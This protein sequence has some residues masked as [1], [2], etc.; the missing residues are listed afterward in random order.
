[1]L[2]P[3]EQSPK[4]SDDSRVTYILD[5]DLV[6]F[7][8]F[9]VAVLAVFLIVG[10]YLFG[11]KLESALEKVR[12]TQEDMK[13]AQEKLSL[14]QKEL[15][16]ALSMTQTLKSDVE[17]VLADAQQYVTEISAQRTVAVEIV[18]SMRELTPQ[19]KAELKAV[20]EQQP[21]KARGDDRGK[22]WKVGSTIRIRFLD[23]DVATHEQVKAIASEW[24]NYVNLRFEF[25]ASGD[26]DIRIKFEKDDGSW[27]YLGTDALAIPKNQ[28]TMN[29]G[30]VD[31]QTVLNQFG[32]ALGLIN[33]HQNP[34]ANIHWNRA[35]IIREMSAP[36]NNWSK[37]EI[38]HNFFKKASEDLYPDY[39]EFDPTSIMAYSYPASWTGGIKIG[40]G[41]DLSE[42]DK[43]FIAKIYPR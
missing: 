30:F 43:A 29:L 21:E 5:R 18:T 16:A 6:R 7:A 25:V 2:L 20:K 12:S 17:K 1:M 41:D 37:E 19:Q 35:L 15:E 33:E 28:Q 10:S 26:A 14:T 27:S 24:T 13:A 23:G 36:P 40:G 9:S 32:H 39:R 8:K 31:K 3:I 4:P 11:F 42:S 22:W 34:K 38:E